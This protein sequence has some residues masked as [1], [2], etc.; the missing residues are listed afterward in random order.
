[1]KKRRPTYAVATELMLDATTEILRRVRRSSRKRFQVSFVDE[2]AAARADGDVLEAVDVESCLAKEKIGEAVLVRKCED[3]RP[4]RWR[5][6][7]GVLDVVVVGV[8]VEVEKAAVAVQRMA[9]RALADAPVERSVV[10]TIIVTVVLGA[11][12]ADWWC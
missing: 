8:R 11:L 3:V 12:D 1:M 4:G 7:V 6:G 10:A 9:L 5:L 2:V